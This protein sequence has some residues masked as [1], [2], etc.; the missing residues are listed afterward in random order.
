MVTQNASVS[1]KSNALYRTKVD[2]SRFK[3]ETSSWLKNNRKSGNFLDMFTKFEETNGREVTTIDY[4]S[5]IK[6]DC[7]PLGRVIQLDAWRVDIIQD[8]AMSR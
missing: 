4:R 8:M 5:V 1:T 2:F 6:Q 3:R 7:L